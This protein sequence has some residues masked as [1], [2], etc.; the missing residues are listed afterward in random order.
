[1]NEKDL[2]PFILVVDDEP[3]IRRL[4]REILEDE[5]Y[6]VVAAKDGAAAKLSIEDQEPDLILL[7]IWMPDID[8]ITLLKEIIE[9]YHLPC[10]VIMMSGHGTVEAA[11]ESTRLG[12]FDFIEKPISLSKLLLTVETALESRQSAQIQTH[13]AHTRIETVDLIG[14]SQVVTQLRNQLDRCSQFDVTV[15]L[16]GDHGVGKAHCARYIHTHSK[17]KDGPFL[18]LQ[19]A[20]FSSFQ[21]AELLLGRQTDGNIKKGFLEKASGGS[22]YIDDVAELSEELQSVLYGVLN[23]PTIYRVNGDEPL[24]IDMRLIVGTRFD[25]EQEIRTGR[26]K[27]ELYYSIVAYPIHIPC[28][29]EH[30]EDVSELLQFYVNYYTEQEGQPYRS[31]TLAA[32]NRLRNYGWPGNIKELEN[33]VHRT[34]IN[35]G[36]TSIDL[37]EVEVL[38]ESH[39]HTQASLGQQLGGLPGFDL[40]LRQAR[41]QFEKAYLTYHLGQSDG[42]VGKVAKLAGMERTHL[43]RKLR[44]LGIDAKQ[45]VQSGK[46]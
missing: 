22:L 18:T 5:G 29:N 32:Q 20:S 35:G 14:K 25:L 6:S 44:S 39:T 31:F 38:L 3:D 40:P 1:V 37:D 33:F 27:E 11:V 41:E 7:D 30:N 16:N 42:S 46:D 24:S 12:A 21:G 10:P 28:L 4:V 13:Y 8:G 26:I 2:K 45:I 15:L 23:S 9:V 19:T 43:Y 36:D 34:L 17:R